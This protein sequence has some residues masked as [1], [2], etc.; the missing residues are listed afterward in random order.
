LHNGLLEQS[1]DDVWNTKQSLSAIGFVDGLSP[2]RT[3]AV[4]AIK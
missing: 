1:I 4:S 3:G 2:H